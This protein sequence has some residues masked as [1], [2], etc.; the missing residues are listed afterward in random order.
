MVL[1]LAIWTALSIAG[2]V[3]DDVERLQFPA[4]FI[5]ALCGV[6][7]VCLYIFG[8]AFVPAPKLM[9]LSQSLELDGAFLKMTK[10]IPWDID[11]TSDNA[12][13]LCTNEGPPSYASIR[14][15]Q[16][17]GDITIYCHAPDGST[18]E[19]LVSG[20]AE[21]LPSPWLGTPKY[22]D[23][24]GSA[25][26]QVIRDKRSKNRFWTSLQELSKSSLQR[27]DDP[28]VVPLGDDDDD[29]ALS[30]RSHGKPGPKEP[31]FGAWLESYGR[32]VS[33]GVFLS[34]QHLVAECRDGVRRA[35]PIGHLQMERETGGLSVVAPDA[36]Y[37][38]LLS[39]AAVAEALC[40]SCAV[41]S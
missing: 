26:L 30:Y 4:A 14:F 2:F 17:E 3:I 13:V 16:D 40:H 39:D 37:S 20:N 1:F 33:A 19:L 38:L 21:A 22:R 28:E 9:E 7:A 8:F 36:T 15:L 10:P 41:E 27:A 23:Q 6:G 11:F 32:E 25:L 35:F 12:Y 34:D 29:D 24:F 18:D 31:G 5:I